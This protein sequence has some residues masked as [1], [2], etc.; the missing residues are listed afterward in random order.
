MR[1]VVFDWAVP[2]VLGLRGVGE[3]DRS[4]EG[5]LRGL[6]VACSL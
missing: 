4:S 5:R 3:G 2:G 1:L 6:G